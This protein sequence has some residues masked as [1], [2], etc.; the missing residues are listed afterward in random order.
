MTVPLLSPAQQRALDDIVR[1]A[2]AHQLGKDEVAEA[3]TCARQQDVP[4]KDRPAG[5]GFL[6]ALLGYLGGALMVSGLFIYAS[7]IWDDIGSLPRVLLSLGS[8]LIAFYA[9]VLVQKEEKTRKASL[10]LWIL[11]A[12]LIPTGLFVFLH[13]YAPGDDPVLGGVIVFGLTMTLYA[14][15]F[16]EFG[17][18]SLLFLTILFGLM[19][20]GTFYEH[21]GLNTPLMWLATGASFLTA[22]VEAARSP[23]YAE[24][25]FL[26]LAVG[27][28]AL[29]SSAYYYLGN[30]DAEGIMAALILGLIFLG[31]RLENR[32]MITLC[33]IFFI[34]LIG[35]HGWFSW[36]YL[37]SDI[38]RLTAAVTGIAMIF[39]GHWLH[40]HTASRLVP[41]WHFFGSSL[42]FSACMGLLY[43]TPF[44]VLFPIAPGLVLLL[45]LKL[46]S[47]ALLLS[48]ILALLSFIGYYT[49][50]YFADTVGWPLALMV[51]GMAMIG[52]CALALKMNGRIKARAA[53]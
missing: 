25:A 45:S 15:A 53:A 35:K 42:L 24:I 52:L 26:P 31:Y 23:R 17:K 28:T 11:S 50:E 10:P 51:T 40:T 27:S 8:G 36:G 18:S 46:S 1:I 29:V 44:D 9:G 7:M 6:T 39:T 3:L 21:A 48:S 14:L 33:T 49:A 47:R 22:G 32:L 12:L 2:H 4:A 16:R 34:V 41:L 30:T 43:L 13:E 19:F 37:D 20:I 38:L 5:N